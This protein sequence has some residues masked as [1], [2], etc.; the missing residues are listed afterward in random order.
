MRL[1]LRLLV[2]TRMRKGLRMHPSTFAFATLLSMTAL[3][4]CTDEASDESFEDGIG[5]LQEQFGDEGK[6]DL[7]GVDACAL[8]E[9]LLPFGDDAIRSGLI[10]GVQ[11]N[12]VLGIGVGYGGFDLAWD[13]YHQQLVVSY[14]GGA[15]LGTP[16]V[17][18]SVTAY[19]GAAFGFENG[20]RDW[21]GH[22]VVTDAQ[23]GLPFLD[24]YI[25]LNPVFFTSP[26]DSDNDGRVAVTEAIAPPD[27]IY[28][29]SLGVTLAYDLL[30]DPLPIEGS[31][32]VGQWAPFKHA[33]RAFYER[34]RRVTI[35][36][37]GA[38]KV[39]LVDSRTGA[40]CP[41]NWPTQSGSRDCVM[42]FGDRN[43]GWVTRS[44]H[45]AYSICTIAGN[46]AVPLSWPMAATAVAIG[47]LRSQDVSISGLCR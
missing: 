11:G 13:L 1:V 35:P 4:A 19:A 7:F 2:A 5:P 16:G 15:G 40:A 44:I 21:R 45:T 17:G 22:S 34:L 14:Y 31:I 25:S 43:Q 9:P 27:G 30:P 8:L 20:A 12:G 26:H 24:D 47:V 41:A 32:T 33:I 37:V 23:I 36:T 39:R 38:L 29:F 6:A 46:C 28:G 42:E 10:L 3:G 18:A